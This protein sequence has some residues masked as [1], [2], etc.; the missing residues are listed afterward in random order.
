MTG[1]TSQR[2]DTSGH[3]GRACGTAALGLLLLSIVLVILERAGTGKTIIAPLMVL[4]A[5][6]VYAGVG[7]LSHAANPAE[8]RLAG[9]SV[10]AVFAGVA[11]GAEWTSAAIVIGAGGSLFV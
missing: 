2:T 5:F 1:P 4:G 9:R 7:L 11:S 8:Y 3:L 10:P 6:A